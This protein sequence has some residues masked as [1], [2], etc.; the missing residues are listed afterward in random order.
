MTTNPT[1]AA[2]VHAFANGWLSYSAA[3]SALRA[4]GIHPARILTIL[5]EAWAPK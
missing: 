1:Q 5:S 3:K 4:I 2:I